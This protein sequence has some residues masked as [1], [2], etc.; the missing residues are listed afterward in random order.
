M[1]KQDYETRRQRL[2]N[3]GCPIHGVGVTQT[4][5]FFVKADG[6]LFA[7]FSCPRGD[8]DVTVRGNPGQ[9]FWEATPE[10]ALLLGEA[11]DTSRIYDYNTLSGA[12]GRI[13]TQVAMR[14]LDYSVETGERPIDIVEAALTEYLDTRRTPR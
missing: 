2:S 5:N 14:A 8:C 11:P 7:I 4:G 9:D 1:A 10:T 13:D 3:G 12:F 6:T